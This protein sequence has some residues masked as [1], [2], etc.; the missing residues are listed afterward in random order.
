[1]AQKIFLFKSRNNQCEYLHRKYLKFAFLSLSVVKWTDLFFFMLKTSP[2]AMSEF[3]KQ[4]FTV[5]F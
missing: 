2:C 5:F 1:M 3:I 4:F